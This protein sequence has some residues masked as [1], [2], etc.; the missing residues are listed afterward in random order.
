MFSK[1]STRHVGGGTSNMRK[2]L[3]GLALAV[4]LALSVGACASFNSQTPQEKLDTAKATVT[5]LEAAY[6]AVCAATPAPAVCTDPKAEAA[7]AAAQSALN[8]TF[9]A[10]QAAINANNG[11]LTA[12]QETKLFTEIAQD[13][14]QLENA[15]NS[16]KAAKK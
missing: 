7:Y 5:S 8:T 3:T 2:G 10:A 11:T 4:T 1:T 15:V 14:V 16:A 9:D 6:G 12:D 13:I